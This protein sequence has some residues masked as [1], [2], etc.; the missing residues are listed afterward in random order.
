MGLL[1]RTTALSALETNFCGR[2]FNLLYVLR[3]NKNAGDPRSSAFLSALVLARE[4]GWLSLFAHRRR[5]AHGLGVRD[6][7]QVTGKH[8]DPDRRPRRVHGHGDRRPRRG[9]RPAA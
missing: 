5:P 6:P 2:F 4:E 8:V 1:V 9:G 7:A 3:D